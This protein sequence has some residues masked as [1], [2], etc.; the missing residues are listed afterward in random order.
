MIPNPLFAVFLPF[1]TT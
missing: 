1:D